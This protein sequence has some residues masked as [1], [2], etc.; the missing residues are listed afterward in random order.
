MHAC[1]SISISISLA[2]NEEETFALVG[3]S[4][5]GK[6]TLGRLILGLVKPSSGRISFLGKDIWNMREPEFREFRRNAQIIHQDPYDTLNPVRTIHQSLSKPLLHHK[7]AHSKKESLEKTRE[8]LEMV[9]LLPPD[10]S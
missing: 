9:G 8:L 3:E 2:L 1:I 5:C 4:G 6:S 10:D 7:I